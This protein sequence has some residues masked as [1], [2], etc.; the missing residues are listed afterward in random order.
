MLSSIG[1]ST[2]W[3]CTWEWCDIDVSHYVEDVTVSYIQLLA[4]CA[5]ISFQTFFVRGH[6]GKCQPFGWDLLFCHF[7]LPSF[8]FFIEVTLRI[9][10]T[11]Q[12]NRWILGKFN[13][14]EIII[15]S[16]IKSIV[17]LLLALNIFFLFNL[18]IFKFNLKL[19]LFFLLDGGFLNFRSTEKLKIWIGINDWYLYLLHGFWG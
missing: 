15:W 14:S 11:F 8:I 6:F 4:N 17:Q 1:F 10:F 3:F 9:F 19:I 7:F 16:I 13:F 12:I 18:N 2:V 5:L